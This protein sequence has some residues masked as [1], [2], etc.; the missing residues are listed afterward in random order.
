MFYVGYSQR[1]SRAAV[2]FIIRLRETLTR[3]I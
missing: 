1:Q 2:A 3:L